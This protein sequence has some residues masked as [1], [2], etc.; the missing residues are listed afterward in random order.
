[1]TQAAETEEVVIRPCEGFAELDACVDLQRCTWGYG[2]LDVIPRRLFV[3]AQRIGGQVIGAFS[4]G[5][6]A[7][8]AMAIPGIR[9]GEPYL[10]SHMLAVAPEYR[11]RGLGR[12]LKLAQREEALARGIRRME[13]TFDPLE[14]KN[15]YLNIARLGAISHS[16]LENAYGL[17]SARLQGGRPT[18][19]LIAEWWMDSDRAR[20]AAAGQ[21]FTSPQPVEETVL[22][23]RAVMDWKEAA[24][25]REPALALQMENRERFQR[26]FARGLAVTGFRRDAQGNG[27]FELSRWMP[28]ATSPTTT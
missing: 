4:S 26:A 15:A 10:H 20:A 12:R 19:R 6:V 16:Y 3:V 24:D 2:D 7:G 17:S 23:P 22:L 27:C 28:P 18:D 1:M 9:D 8:F 11:N 13:W 5:Q 14:I 25:G 21:P